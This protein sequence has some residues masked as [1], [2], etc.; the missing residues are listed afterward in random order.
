MLSRS[1]QRVVGGKR[2]RGH[3]WAYPPLV[4]FGSIVRERITMSD[5]LGSIGRVVSQLVLSLL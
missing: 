3:G 2:G 5:I 1:L 4:F